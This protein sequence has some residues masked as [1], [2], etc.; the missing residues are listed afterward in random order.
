LR[1]APALDDGA[2]PNRVPIP[3]DVQTWSFLATGRKG[4]AASIDWAIGNLSACG[5]FGGL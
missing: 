3:E 5:A 2:S 1:G 4:Y